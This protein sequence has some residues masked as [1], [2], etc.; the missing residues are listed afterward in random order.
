MKINKSRDSKLSLASQ[1][2]FNRLNRRLFLRL[3]AL[4]L[5]TFLLVNAIHSA[6]AQ[7]VAKSARSQVV[8]ISLDGATPRIIDDYLAKGVLNRRTGLGLLQ[9]RVYPRPR[10]S[11]L[12]DP[13]FG[14]GTHEL[15]AQ[16][17]MSLQRSKRVITSMALKLL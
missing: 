11:D 13:A 16:A 1:R 6:T 10:S 14:L 4:A 7:S 12:N 15:I 8:L 2:I 9:S 17:A 5:V 3:S